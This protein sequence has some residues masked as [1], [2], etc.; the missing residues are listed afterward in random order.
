MT[1]KPGPELDERTDTLVRMVNNKV[2]L[3]GNKTQE[4]TGVPFGKLLT[5]ATG[6]EKCMLWTGWIFAGLTGAIL[7]LFFFFLG[8]IF[9]S[10]G[11][12]NSPEETRDMV[13]ELCIIMFCIAIG[14][15]IT[16]YF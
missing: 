1:T 14:I 4:G 11:G 15:M 9:D 12:N 10:F 3:E 13:R 2:E 5:E 6:T 16:C 8:P 7:P